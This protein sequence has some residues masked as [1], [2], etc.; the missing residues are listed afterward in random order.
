MYAGKTAGYA[1]S[2]ATTQADRAAEA[3][4]HPYLEAAGTLVAAAM[5]GHESSRRHLVYFK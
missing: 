2:P 1:G 4:V 3:A 5:G